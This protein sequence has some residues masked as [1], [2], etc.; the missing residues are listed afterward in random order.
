MAGNNCTRGGFLCEGYSSR[1]T[2]QKPSSSKA[3]VPL[4]SKEGYPEFAGQ[5]IT[6]SGQ[7]HDRQLTE[8][9]EAGKLRPV[10]L[11]EPDRSAQ[12][13]NTSPTA[14]ASSASS[15]SKRGWHGTGHPAYVSEHLAKDYREVPPIHELPRDG[16]PASDY[17]V[18]PSIRE[19]SHGPLPNSNMPLFQAGVEQRPLPSTVMD[20]NSPQAQARMAL[21][22]EN[23]LSGRTVSNSETEKEKM[24]RG[25]LYRPF[26]VQLVDERDRCKRALW[27]FNNACN[28]LS[29]VSASE[30]SRLLK[31]VLMPPSS[32]VVNSPSGVA[33]PRSAGSIGVGVVVEAPFHCHYGYNVHLAED[34]MVSENC[35]FIDDCPIKIGAHTWIGPR[36]TIL[37]SMAHANMQERKGTQSRY[38]GRQVT[39]E[40]D[41]Y[42][43]A[44]CILYPGV[45]VGRG[46]Y[47]APGEVVRAD[48]PAYSFQ[49]LKPSYM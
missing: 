9:V 12:Q 6:E 31:E 40:E 23:Q 3:P 14:T 28:S 13:Y 37:S 48:I 27:R 38:L 1:S 47:V 18:V 16:H 8:H 30:Q 33:A 41:C 20:T 2:W 35:S 39:I 32:S 15:W 34:V 36:V 21:S 10:G 29:G 45:R 46:A 44:G 49:G 22:I 7:H 43:S 42:V 24:L 17:A 4:Q 25:E 5:Y 11:D 19:L 26:D